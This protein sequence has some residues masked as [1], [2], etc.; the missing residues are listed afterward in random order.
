MVCS[1]VVGVV[2]SVWKAI[3]AFWFKAYHNADALSGPEINR[4]T[5]GGQR[6]AG[7]RAVSPV[8][9]GGFCR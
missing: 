2:D 3:P 6:G 7:S 4:Q 1:P 8:V 5:G 9:T